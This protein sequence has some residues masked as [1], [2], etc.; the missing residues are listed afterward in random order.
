M[1][2]AEFSAPV[3]AMS[4]SIPGFILT[5]HWRDTPLGVRVDLWLATDQGPLEVHLLAR[6]SVFFV[7]RRE[8]EKIL[9]L[10]QAQGYSESE[11]RSA[12]VNMKTPD[13]L[14][15]NALYFTSQ[16]RLTH[17][18]QQLQ[19][20]GL[21]CWESDIRPPERLLMERSIY[22]AIEVTPSSPKPPAV[23][24]LDNPQIAPCD[25]KPDFKVISLDIET[26][27]D[28]R[29][30]YSIGL[31]CE[32]E[33]IV[34]MV[35]AEDTP[36]D[37]DFT[38]NYCATERICIERFLEWLHHFDPDIIIGWN[39]VQFDMWALECLCQRLKI[40]F[41][42]GRNRQTPY[43]RQDPGSEYRHMTLSGRVVLDGIE[44]L[45]T[46]FYNFQSFT[47]QFVAGELLGDGK[48]L[49]G[50]GRGEE[51]S[52]LFIT[53]KPALARYNL[54]DCKLVWDIFKCT[55]LLDFSI[56]RS[57]L[58]G[59][60]L[61]RVGGSA[62]SFDYAYLPK[63]H[64]AGYVAPTL[65]D[66]S[67]DIVSPGGYVMDSS[68]GLYSNV[69]VL[70]FKSLY[71]SIMRTF[72]V[73][74]AGFWM[75]QAKQ[76]NGSKVVPGFHGARFAKQGHILP[77]IV[78][79]LWA[80]RDSAKKSGNKPLS[81][82]IKILM[83]SFYG[84][85]GSPVCRFFDPRVSSSITMRGHEILQTTKRWIE[86]RDWQVIYG[87]T[88]SVFVWLNRDC[89]VS[90]AMAEGA[91]LA[92]SLNDRW[93]DDIEQRFGVESELELEFETLYRQFFMPTIRGSLEG[94]K[95]RYAGTVVT[96][97]EAGGADESVELVFKGLETVRTDWTDL[98]K[99]FQRELYRR[100]FAK[101]PFED[102]IRTC[103]EQ[104]YSGEIDSELVYRKRLRR[105]LH[106]YK[107]NIPPQVIAAKKWV[108]ELRADV[109]RGDW[110]EYVFTVNG[111]EPI[112]ALNSN[113]DYQRYIERQLA[114]VADSILQFV[115]TSFAEIN[116]RQIG[117][118]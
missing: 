25:F 102:Y 97:V 88:D 39:I 101:E 100:V 68:P 84:V 57:Q 53:D 83:N 3:A 111:P 92:E 26:S 115:G 80:Q 90:E 38:L 69:L 93:R 42:L 64:R 7:L 70:D 45:K 98:A 50:S 48:L 10:L 85:L 71:P 49:Q 34:F 43:W 86:E 20:Q 107:R 14:A 1:V 17:A 21:R 36:C 72:K 31:W 116:D 60:K 18:R 76:L 33:R 78:A 114:P 109:R 73:D 74:P 13:N 117:L 8:C 28:A 63:L 104:L 12:E 118:F 24:R 16:K 99:R 87:D 47:L 65:G 105:Q 52:E 54:Q 56:A 112:Q 23:S 6:E 58:T 41:T 106:E 30:L 44:L 62:A 46:A 22:A 32:E 103:V 110:I 113:I 40:K 77:N 2:G 19:G 5:R 35:G 108:L 91:A 27:M 29:R 81:Q 11:L 94:S 15:V 9:H 75:A 96:A 95:K 82:A 89:T 79:E 37:V 61:D 51:I 59:M 55:D 66:L 4:E 67:S